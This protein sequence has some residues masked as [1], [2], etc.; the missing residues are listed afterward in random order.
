MAFPPN[1]ASV[2][3]GATPAQIQRW[4]RSQLV[5]PEVR[6]ERPPLYSFRDV[7]LLR[8]IAYLRAHIS[9]Q[10]IHAS[11][12]NLQHLER[13]VESE[14]GVV[15]AVDHPSKYQFATDGR[16]VYVGMPD[17]AAF[18]LLRKVTRDGAQPTVFSFEA[19]LDTF[20][21]FRGHNVA[22]FARPAPHIEVDRH[23]LGGWPTIEG[24]RIQYD[25]VARLVDHATI[26]PEDVEDY[27]PGVQVQHVMGAIALAD[28]VASVSA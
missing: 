12:D 7:V 5:V 19:M 20:S 17:G 27:Y 16:S 10:K 11:F 15:D 3:S 26:W 21:N 13:I 28:K 23:R 25:T 18:D 2:L 6:A 22:P 24:T 14:S 1:M 8:S 9:S 4:R